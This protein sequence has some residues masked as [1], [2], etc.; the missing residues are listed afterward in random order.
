MNKLS[1]YQLIIILIS[2][3]ILFSC[4]MAGTSPPPD[5][6]AITL[7][8][9]TLNDGFVIDNSNTIMFGFEREMKSTDTEISMTLPTGI[10]TFTVTKNGALGQVD[11]ITDTTGSMI[12]VNKSN[13]GSI[14]IMDFGEA[15]GTSFFVFTIEA[16][17]I[18]PL[19][20]C[21]WFVRPLAETNV[22]IQFIRTIPIISITCPSSVLSGAAGIILNAGATKVSYEGSITPA[23]S[24]TAFAWTQTTGPAVTLNGADTAV[25]S[26]NA[27]VTGVDTDLTFQLTV[28]DDAGLTA[29][30]E[31]TVTV[32]AP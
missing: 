21:D 7:I 12:I 8:G 18:V 22:G 19:G 17:A 9:E 31:V 15:E 25:L 30:E 23:P 16:P 14:L 13:P 32:L 5:S 20:S 24:I 1:F 26:F 29:T 28:T 27:P 11:N 6:E 2:L 4:S 10:N 3:T